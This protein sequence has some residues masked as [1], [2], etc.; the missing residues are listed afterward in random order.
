MPRYFIQLSFKGTNFHGWQSQ[1][2]AVTVQSALE[3][4]LHTL[5]HEEI[6]TT[7]AGRTDTGVHARYFVAHFDTNHPLPANSGDF[8]YKMNA[9]LPGDIALA[10]IFPVKSDSHARFSAISRTY[11]YYISRVKDPLNAEF[12]WYLSIPLNVSLMNE[13]ASIILQYTDFTSFSKLHSNVNNNTCTIV[14]TYWTEEDNVLQFTICANRFLRN[15][16]RSIVGTM[17]EIGR[18]KI[19]LATLVK[20]IEAKDRQVAG[21]S[22]PAR[23]L[24]LADIQYVDDIKL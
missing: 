19:D 2:N 12:S 7:G 6:K 3:K 10:D 16:V 18:G 5:L 1:H 24:F 11:I 17:I 23:G 22:A 14:N 13:A 4:A 15:M 21:F 9:I 8:L 20:I